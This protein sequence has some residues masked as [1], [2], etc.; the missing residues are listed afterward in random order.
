M[1]S[2]VK[3]SWKKCFVIYTDVQDF[4]AVNETVE[5]GVDVTQ[6]EVIIFIADNSALE[7]VEQFIVE[8]EPVPGV[9][10]VAVMDNIATITIIDNDGILNLIATAIPECL[11]LSLSLFQLSFLAL[12]E[13]T[14]SLMSSQKQHW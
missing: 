10:P 13:L 4:S 2:A 1:L 14:T 11:S 5:F 8:I 9:F 6:M 7:D 12:R 3:F